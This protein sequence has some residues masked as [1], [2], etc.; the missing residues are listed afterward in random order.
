M[1]EILYGTPDLTPEEEQQIMMQSEQSA[2]DVQV[3]ESMAQQQAL[4]TEAA[5]TR[6]SYILIVLLR[7]I[8]ANNVLN[9]NS[10]H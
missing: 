7:I 10:C 5:P 2:Q 3:M 6:S 4:Q 9:I 8:F 1:Q